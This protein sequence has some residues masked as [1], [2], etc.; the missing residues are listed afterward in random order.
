MIKTIL[1]A[2]PTDKYIEAKTFKAIFDLEV[3]VGYKVDFRPYVSNQIDTIRNEIVKETLRDNYNYLFSIDSD[4]VL[5]TDALKKMLEADKDMITGLYIQRIEDTHTVEVYRST[6]GDG[7][8]HIPYELLKG[9]GI[10]E[11]AGCGFGCVLVKRKVMEG[12]KYPY[13]VYR[14]A[15]DHAHTYSEDVY[16]CKQATDAGFTIWADTSILCDHLGS[17]TFKVE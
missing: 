3:P 15:L 10:V 6:N 4:I 12:L 17:R 9:K 14:S 1:I 5:P 11:V 8:A 13:F 2:V 7:R 16:F